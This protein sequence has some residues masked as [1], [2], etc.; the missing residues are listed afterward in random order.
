MV[1]D[2]IGPDIDPISSENQVLPQKE[3]YFEKNRKKKHKLGPD[4]DP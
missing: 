1:R 2:M 3:E 4:V